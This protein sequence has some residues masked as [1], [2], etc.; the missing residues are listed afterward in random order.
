M[1]LFASFKCC[2]KN[3]HS[4]NTMSQL[5][6]TSTSPTNASVSDAS[7]TPAGH[8]TRPDSRLDAV[9]DLFEASYRLQNILN[10]LK[11][12]VDLVNNDSTS[13]S[14]IQKNSRDVK[15]LIFPAIE[16]IADIIQ[17]SSKL[18]VPNRSSKID[19]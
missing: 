16:K 6:T 4:P 5:T 17:K 8:K 10:E 2:H 12:Y 15:Q 9:N 18:V 19:S 14:A 3:K 7:A 13:K 1:E 11:C